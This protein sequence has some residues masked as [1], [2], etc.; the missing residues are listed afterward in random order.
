MR[1]AK[2]HG[3][4]ND[5]IMLADPEDRIEITSDLARALCNRRF[6]VGGDGVIR[7][8]PGATAPTC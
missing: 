2:W 6:G 7:V 4:G 3:I 1:F 5:F 8:A